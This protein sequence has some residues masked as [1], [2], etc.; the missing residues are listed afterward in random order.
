MSNEPTFGN[1]SADALRLEILRREMDKMSEKDRARAAEEKAR[2][3]FATDFMRHHIG[4]DELRHIRQLV[5]AAVRHGAFQA[6]VYSFPSSLCSDD[7]RAINNA[8]PEWPET[9][10]GKARE[11]YDT[12]ERHARPLGYH[13]HASIISFPGGVPGDV[14]FFLSWEPPVTGAAPASVEVVEKPD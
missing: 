10:R 11:L 7:G 6:M 9:L 14:G 13:L 5:E 4:P 8:R 1:W 3:D 12:F 2:A